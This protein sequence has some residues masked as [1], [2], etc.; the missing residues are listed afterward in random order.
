MRSSTGPGDQVFKVRI[1]Q[2]QTFLTG[3]KRITHAGGFK[4][5]VPHAKYIMLSNVGHLPHYL[6]QD[7][8]RKEIERVS[9]SA[10][11]EMGFD[12]PFEGID[13]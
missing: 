1:K 10:T 7:I 2:L 13:K 5:Q 8:I 11:S 9:A 6:H 4:Y 12:L 3:T